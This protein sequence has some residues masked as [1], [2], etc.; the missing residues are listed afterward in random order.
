MIEIIRAEFSIISASELTFLSLHVYLYSKLSPK[1]KLSFIFYF[2]IIYLH[3]WYSGGKSIQSHN[4]LKFRLW[5]HQPWWDYFPSELL[6]NSAWIH[7]CGFLKPFES[8]HNRNFWFGTFD[9][10]AATSPRNFR[11]MVHEVTRQVFWNHFSRNTGEKSDLE[12][13]TVMR[14]NACTNTDNSIR[15]HHSGKCF[16]ILYVIYK[17]STFKLRISTDFSTVFDM[18]L[19]ST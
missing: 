3:W 11:P 18:T 14:L 4:G 5:N 15:S 9:H 17:S 7:P 13:S 12:L 16:R 10:S 6:T 1:H 8:L 2:F 19:T